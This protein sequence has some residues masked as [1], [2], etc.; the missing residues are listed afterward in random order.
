MRDVY[1]TSG[2]RGPVLIRSMAIPWARR[3]LDSLGADADPEVR[4]A[5]EERAGLDGA[6][7][8]PAA[9]PFGDPS[10]AVLR[11]PGGRF[12]GASSRE[13]GRRRVEPEEPPAGPSCSGCG[14]PLNPA[15][16]LVY[17]RQGP[18]GSCTRRNHRK[19]VEGS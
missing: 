4:R 12:V 2:R 5:L 9:V 7:V 18:C 16:V 19:A 14:R 17:G 3:A 11:G 6:T 15:A 8:E 1:Y 10:G 13:A